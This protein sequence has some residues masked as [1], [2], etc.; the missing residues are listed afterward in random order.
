MVKGP[1]GPAD[2]GGNDDVRVNSPKMASECLG[3]ALVIANDYRD[4]VLSKGRQPLPGTLKDSNDYIETFV[5]YL[6]YKVVVRYNLKGNGIC[7]AIDDLISEARDC[8]FGRAD[9]CIAFVFCGHGDE[10]VIIGQ[11]GVKVSLEVIFNRFTS[12]AENEHLARLVKLFFIDAC[13]GVNEDRG[14]WTPRGGEI[15]LE[16]LVPTEGNMLIAYSTLPWYKAYEFKYKGKPQGL[17]SCILNEEL[18]KD[19][20]IEESLENIITIVTMRMEE[21]SKKYG[22]NVRFQTPQKVATLRRMLKPLK[23]AREFQPQPVPAPRRNRVTPIQCGAPSLPGG[24]LFPSTLHRPGAVSGGEGV[25]TAGGQI[26]QQ[27][28]LLEDSMHVTQ[29]LQPMAHHSH[30][31]GSPGRCIHLTV[32][33]V[34]T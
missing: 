29:Q 15:A 12:S 11:D 22:R 24:E 26:P 33:T 10:G 16:K 28:I 19:A 32:H 18:R 5:E 20:N 17:F 2:A 31:S 6:K 23:E 14:V 25:L 4:P 1:I 13:R 27:Q 7:H 34:D 3:L 30:I 21:E 8:P 9:A